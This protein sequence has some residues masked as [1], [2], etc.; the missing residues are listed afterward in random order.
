MPTSYVVTTGEYSSYSIRGVYSTREKADYAAR[1]YGGDVEEYEIDA[2]PD[3]PEGMVN[4]YVFM[5]KDGKAR[6]MHQDP[7]TEIRPP[8]FYKGELH[9]STWAKDEAHAIKIANEIRG[10][11]IALNEW[12]DYVEPV[13]APGV[14]A[15][16][17][18]SMASHKGPYVIPLGGDGPNSA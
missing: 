12:P 18:T 9:V 5:E 2:L 16:A 6:T 13:Y 3:H 17:S 10:Q 7:D 15:F 1:L 11:K 14:L 4:I 8:S